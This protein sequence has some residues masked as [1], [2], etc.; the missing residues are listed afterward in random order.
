M[1]LAK[2]FQ[3]T[4]LLSLV[5]GLFACVSAENRSQIGDDSKDYVTEGWIDDDTFQVRTIGAPSSRAK[6][7]VRRRT[8]SEEAA[9]LSA[10]KRVIELL[11]GAKV[12]GASGSDSGESTGVVLTKELQGVIKG[13]A[14]VKKSFDKEDNCEIVYRIQASGLKEMAEIKATQN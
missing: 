8:Q 12:S 1:K 10:Q 13:G 3:I 11:V 9:L 14:V 6:G 4:I 5:F 2:K 7:L